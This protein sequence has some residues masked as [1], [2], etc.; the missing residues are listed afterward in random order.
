MKTVKTYTPRM[1]MTW[2][3]ITKMMINMRTFKELL[4][5]MSKK[6]MM[7]KKFA[8]AHR[9]S[10]HPPSEEPGGGEE[11]DGDKE[12]QEMQDDILTVEE[13]PQP[14]PRQEST[15]PQGNLPNKG[16]QGRPRRRK[17]PLNNF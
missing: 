15:L 3:Q 10:K 13:K 11:E 12:E 14:L 2:T 1:S 7:N 16:S 4:N 17:R 6:K 8:D 5:H 9:V